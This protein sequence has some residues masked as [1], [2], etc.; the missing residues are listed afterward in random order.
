MLS[1]VARMGRSDITDQATR[2]GRRGE[3]SIRRWDRAPGQPAEMNPGNAT[4]STATGNSRDAAST[5]QPA[6][7]RPSRAIISGTSSLPVATF[8]VTIHRAPVA[9]AP[10]APAYARET[11]AESAA[12]EP[13]LNHSI[14]ARSYCRETNTS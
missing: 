2:F 12:V 3:R 10:N 13:E 4:M 1:I 9:I 6:T 8:V 7:T 5:V 11:T 14:G